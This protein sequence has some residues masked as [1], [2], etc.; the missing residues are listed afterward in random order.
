MPDEKKV[1]SD[2]IMV[3]CD[4]IC[5]VDKKWCG[6]LFHACYVMRFLSVHCYEDDI[7]YPEYLQG[8]PHHIRPLMGLNY[9][10]RD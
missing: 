8:V 2:E 4:V 9:D 6:V 10:F 3:S 5:G 1:W 7:S